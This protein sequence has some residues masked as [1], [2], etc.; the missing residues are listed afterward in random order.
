MPAV[1]RLLSEIAPL[2]ETLDTADVEQLPN[3]VVQLLAKHMTRCVTEL[4]EEEAA[5]GSG[6]AA[7]GPSHV[8]AALLRPAL[9][10]LPA[11]GRQPGALEVTPL[12]RFVGAVSAERLA[13]A[14]VALP[15]QRY[16]ASAPGAPVAP[17]A[18][19]AEGPHSLATDAAQQS[20]LAKLVA[21]LAG[22]VMPE[23]LA[24][25]RAQRPHEAAAA[26]AEWDKALAA[27]APGV[28]RMAEVLR[29]AVLPPNKRDRRRGAERGSGLHMPGLVR[30]V[31]TDFTYKKARRAAALRIRLARLLARWP[32]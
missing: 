12:S 13:A 25:V 32:R 30:A 2:H 4:A 17:A 7:E 29:S 15:Q 19:A 28:E 5:A 14:G 26:Q 6:V 9:A 3:R 31:A 24:A 8:A 11:G 27:V 23:R 22:G 21:E 20:A 1:Q 18:E 16:A 10:D